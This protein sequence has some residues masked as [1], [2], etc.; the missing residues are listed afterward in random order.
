MTLTPNA[1]PKG[2]S[3]GTCRFAGTHVHAGASDREKVLV[4]CHRFPAQRLGNIPPL[5]S[6]ALTER[7]GDTVWP[8]LTWD[9]WCGEWVARDRQN[10]PVAPV[11]ASVTVKP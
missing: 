10:R 5:H 4:T 8:V 11:K 3:C 1:F 6:L 7:L 9:D 2:E